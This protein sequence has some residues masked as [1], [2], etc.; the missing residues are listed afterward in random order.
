MEAK[1]NL[2]PLKGRFRIEV[3]DKEGNVIDYHED[4]NMIMNAAR[5]TMANSVSG[6]KQSNNFIN[7]FVMGT[8]GHVG[9]SILTPKREVHGF[10]PTRNDLFCG[11]LSDAVTDGKKEGV[12]YCVL[13]FDPMSLDNVIDGT[14]NHSKIKVEVTGTQ[15]DEPVIT[16]TI[17]IAQDAFNGEG[18]GMVFT[19]CGLFTANNDIFAMKV[20]AGKVKEK[21]VGFRIIWNILF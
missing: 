3:I 1:D 21:T 14:N 17:E 4:N 2:K 8:A 13:T 12:D 6:L 18:E 19:E 9:N 20:F 7:K 15:Y 5:N 11:Y 10:M 16:Y